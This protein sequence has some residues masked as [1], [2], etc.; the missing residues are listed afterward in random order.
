MKI[1]SFLSKTLYLPEHEVTAFINTA[2]YRYK[3]YSIPKRNGTGTRQIAQ[4][5][6]EVKVLQTLAIEKIKNNLPIHSSAMAY[7]EGLSIKDN[8]SMHAKN[9]F[10]LKMDF[11]NF[12]HSLLPHDLLLHTEKYYSSISEEDKKTLSKLFFWATKRDRKLKLSIGAPS[13]PFI[14]NTLLYDFDE[15]VSNVCRPLDITYTRYADDLTFTTNT[16][17]ILFEIPDL[18]QKICETLTYPKLKINKGKTVFSSKKHNRHITG[19]TITNEATLSLGR[20]RKRHIRSLVH[21]HM[22]G[23][24]S[25]KQITEL[26]GLLA[27]SKHIELTFYKTLVNKYGFKTLLDIQATQTKNSD[28]P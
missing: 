23:K 27:F 8:A 3:E 13:S 20:H 4:P 11:E 6:S 9:K 15:A 17:K 16:N 5:S 26:K 21:Q 22:L 10:L 28:T 2:P 19:I 25:S 7:R 12:F 1:I 14:S 18:I 24:L